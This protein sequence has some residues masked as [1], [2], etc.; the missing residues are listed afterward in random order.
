M[1]L[2]DVVHDAAKHPWVYIGFEVTKA[3]T[4]RHW[5][6]KTIK[7]NCFGPWYYTASK[8]ETIIRKFPDGEGRA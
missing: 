3:K 7:G 2:G 6:V 4:F 5:F 1:K 8:L